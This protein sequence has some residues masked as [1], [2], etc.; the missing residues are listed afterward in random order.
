MSSE[1]LQSL[2]IRIRYRHSQAQCQVDLGKY[3]T[4]VS[5]DIGNPL[6][7][8]PVAIG[9]HVANAQRIFAIL[10]Q[11]GP[12]LLL[13]YLDLHLYVQDFLPSKLVDYFSSS[14]SAIPSLLEFI[15]EVSES[16]ADGALW[17]NF[18]FGKPFHMI[19]Q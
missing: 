4:N 19:G 15:P 9:N 17:F 6:A 13:L 18:V 16:L 3:L 5:A 2:I 10:S 7:N 8:Y 11:Y 14:L 1:Y 12:Y